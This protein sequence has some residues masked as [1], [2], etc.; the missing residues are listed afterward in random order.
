MNLNLS[1]YKVSSQIETEDQYVTFIAQH[2]VDKTFICLKTTSEF[3]ETVQAQQ[4]L[5]YYF[6]ILKKVEH[7]RVMKA[8]GLVK[9]DNKLTLALSKENEKKL[10]SYL[11]NNTFN[12][13]VF[14]SIALA[15]A[16][17][18]KFIH[19]K[20][21]IHKCINPKN[22]ILEDGP[23]KILLKGFHVAE[24]FSRE[25]QQPN[26]K[27]ALEA[28]DLLYVSPEQTGRMNTTMDYRTDF[29]SLGTVYYEILTGNPPFKASSAMGIIHNHIAKE[30]IPPSKS[31]PTIP[32]PLENIV[33]RL[34]D[35]NA[36]NRY[37]SAHGLLFDLKKCHDNLVS[38][39]LNDEFVIGSHDIGN[40]FKI[41]NKIY[42]RELEIATLT[43]LFGK[44]FKGNSSF[45]LISGYAGAGK[46][47]LINEMGKW[48]N[49]NKGFFISGKFAQYKSNI[50]L[51]S[52]N[53]AFS[54]LIKQLLSEDEA[55][56]EHWRTKLTTA[57]GNNGRLLTEVIPELE[58]L[59]GEQP[60][61]K[62]LPPKESNQRFN[63]VL[64]NFV[65]A[66]SK[67]E[68]PLF[69]FLDDLQWI[70]STTR[71]WIENLY[72]NYDLKYLTIIGAYRDNEVSTAHP[73]NFM[74][75]RLKEVK[76]IVHEI[77]LKP[78]S[79]RAL[80]SFV[81]DTILTDIESARPLAELVLEK[82]Y[83]NPFFAKQCLLSL[84]ENGAIYFSYTDNKWVYNL[85]KAKE[86]SIS[87][88]VVDLMLA[89]INGLT[90][91]I[92]NILKI[93]AC[94]GDRFH[95][96]L[97]N[98]I[99]GQKLEDTIDQLSIAIKKGLLLP[100][101][102]WNKLELE[103]YKFLHDRIHQAAYLLSNDAEKKSI[104]LTIG[105]FL[106]E[107]GT[108]S[109]TEETVYE[110][111]D[112]LNY[113]IDLITSN[114]ELVKLAE[115]N[116]M[117]SKRARNSNAYEASLNYVVKALEVLPKESFKNHGS[118]LQKLYLQRAESEHLCN[119]HESAEKYYDL[120]LS[121]AENPLD[122]ALICRSKIHYYTNLGKFKEAYQIGIEALVPLGVKLPKHFKPPLLILEL[123]KYIWYRGSKKISDIS[124]HRIMQ[125]E[126]LKMA[127]LLMSTI[128]KSAYQIKPELC[129]AVCTKIVNV[130]LKHG[131]TEGISIGY[132]AFGPIFIGS[133]LNRKSAG[134][135][136]GELTLELVEQYKSV[137]YKAETHFVVGYFALPW[138][139][140][141]IEM[142]RYWQIAYESGLELGDF[143][144]A[145]CACCGSTQSYF[146]RGMT[147]D[148]ILKIS[149]DYLVFLNQVKNEEA[150]LTIQTVRQ[151]ILNLQGK[152]LS[153]LS[154]DTKEFDESLSIKAYENFESR[155]FAHYY[156]INK[157]QVLYLR[158]DFEQAYEVSL[159]SNSYLKD[160]PGMLHTAE[161]F[162]FKAL[163]ICSLY[164]N[165]GAIQRLKW[166]R[167]VKSIL[168][169][170]HT[171]SEG[172]P[173]NFLHKYQLLK[174]QYCLITKD[175]SGMEKSLFEAVES[176]SKYGYVQVQALANFLLA[177][178]YD[179]IKNNKLASV[180]MVDAVAC[181]KVWGAT[182]LAATISSQFN[183]LFS[184]NT[185]K[186]NQSVSSIAPYETVGKNLDL[187]TILKS[188]EIISGQI[189]LQDL[190]GNLIKIIVENAGAQ[191]I[192]LLLKYE[193]GLSV[194]GEYDT[195]SDVS[196]ILSA[197][198]LV[199]YSS[200]SKP[201]V[202]YVSNSLEPVILDDASN[203]E[204]YKNDSYF[205][206]NGVHSVLCL[207][208]ISQRK[209]IGVIYLENNLA[210]NVFT[211]D[212]INLIMLL[213]G[214]IAIS[215]ENA[216]LYE[217]LEE[218]VKE[219]THELQLEKDKSDKLLLNILPP[220]TAEELKAT[221]TTKAKNFE[222]VTILFTDFVNFTEQ[223]E[224][225]TPQELV[226][227]INYYYSV[228]DAIVHK[229]NVEKIKTIGDSYMC[230]SGLTISKNADATDMVNVALEIRD[231]IYSERKK[232]LG[233]NKS[234]FEIRI[235]INTGPVVA[236]V[237]GTK[238][239][240]YDIW[241]DA[242]N[243]ASR[244]ESSG[245]P[246]HIN[247]SGTTFELIKDYFNCT[248][249]GKIQAKNKGLVDMYFV[250]DKK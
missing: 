125:D 186:P 224:K 29:Y 185:S 196:N 209:L 241:G 137:N 94:I 103:D 135:K 144:H 68:H 110:I 2:L 60:L 108:I 30:I 206:A 246:G 120:A 130:C 126:N 180:L 61:I 65:S 165:A 191:R 215:L 237:V 8:L 67:P 197:I 225:L 17:T 129:I 47:A 77:N 151:S 69:I 56:I 194:Q 195:T 166:R 234:S 92:Q 59:I 10:S 96:D 106:L 190:L 122:N 142:E 62:P 231:F 164:E 79:K 136:F 240:A 97:L 78:L 175:F 203:S 21:V 73:V 91:D 9:H 98:E 232:R 205:I 161:H 55:N 57:L 213:S 32:K 167:A 162:Y 117:A 221:G 23:E 210:N 104:H 169:R 184:L 4:K 112:H 238:K 41:P 33:L 107:K 54:S 114:S 250:D 223:S 233:K 174:G 163:I 182:D 187:E 39:N 236:G 202:N 212:R 88:N 239:F 81:A 51:Y 49:Q 24:E 148:E 99:S 168:N 228:F 71:Q 172:C 35:K 86:A 146:M 208:L 19:D 31:N 44:T 100:V 84:N 90:A 37:Q 58:L 83:G 116:F 198:P 105:K 218:K 145:S 18:V 200:I 11:Q 176:A 159:V 147:F 46:S 149:D 216:L 7:P 121:I 230:A 217:S 227:E 38:N 131:N 26:T 45:V 183:H 173:D 245:E 188:A 50:P 36:E 156:F 27:E 153:K 143:F 177:K 132:L 53:L 211:F 70:D 102:S 75:E 242:V 134:Y 118:L 158:E 111:A 199:D 5:K 93:A 72:L 181:F 220:E 14:F 80:N 124:H 171:Y 119:N 235:G 52:L 95:I 43:E 207:P 76:N 229:Y 160:S 63:L 150:I 34:L 3:Q 178:Y 244:M 40:W 214:Q 15:L 170:F 109:E 154:F 25:P 179:T 248:Y 139:K 249:R 20:K 22:I 16:E 133:I 115:V 89:Q 12:I 243:V 101:F 141:A 157:M 201:L 193:K 247:I 64:Q 13:D 128:A 1:E 28:T 138:R 123:L 6:E 74:L 66:F 127:V 222:V 42:G 82:T 87:E 204:A 140:P 189:K 155:H 192:V 226:T 85:E 152:T 113:S 48:I 219:R